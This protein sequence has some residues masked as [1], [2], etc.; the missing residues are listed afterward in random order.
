MAP[1]LVNAMGFLAQDQI[2]RAYLSLSVNGA[3]ATRQM[4]RALSV[5]FYLSSIH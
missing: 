3:H 1:H 4:V 5:P 2:L